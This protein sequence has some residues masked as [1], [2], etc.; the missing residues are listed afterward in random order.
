MTKPAV[1]INTPQTHTPALP[2]MVLRCQNPNALNHSSCL[3][4][5]LSG[6]EVLVGRSNT[7]HAVLL[8]SGISRR[9]TRLYTEQGA[10]HVE[11]LNSANGTHVNHQRVH[12]ARLQAGD[13]VAFGQVV[14]TL[15]HA[16]PSSEDNRDTQQVFVAELTDG[17]VPIR[18]LASPGPEDTL[19]TTIL[20]GDAIQTLGPI[21]STSRKSVWIVLAITV[22][23][24]I[25]IGGFLLSV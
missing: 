10:W 2:A 16:P 14:Y 8:A 17:S 23:L 20:F 25:T 3:E 12:K 1:R 24:A 18:A 4:I 13:S 9:H 15:N 5:H 21:R 6:S 19:E 11:D 22:I 7:N